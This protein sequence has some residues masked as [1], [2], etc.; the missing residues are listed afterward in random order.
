MRQLVIVQPAGQ[1]GL[2]QMGSNML[3]WHLLRTSLKEVGFLD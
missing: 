3:V 1:F 2:L